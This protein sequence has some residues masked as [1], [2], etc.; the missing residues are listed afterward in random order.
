MELLRVSLRERGLGQLQAIICTTGTPEQA[1]T[2]L[3]NLFLLKLVETGALA[4]TSA[5]TW[6]GQAQSSCLHT[7][8]KKAFPGD[9]KKEGESYCLSETGQEHSPGAQPR[10]DLGQSQP[11]EVRQ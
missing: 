8:S 10:A 11:L 6:G 4:P 1:S 7:I 2:E 3:F 9:W 5:R